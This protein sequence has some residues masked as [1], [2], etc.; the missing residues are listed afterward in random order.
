MHR[1][2]RGIH[3]TPCEG[4]NTSQQP[5]NQDPTLSHVRIS[6][7]ELKRQSSYAEYSFGSEQASCSHCLDESS[8]G[9][10]T[11]ST[12]RHADIC[13]ARF[14]TSHES[15]LS[16]RSAPSSTKIQLPSVPRPQEWKPLAFPIDESC[17]WA[18]RLNREEQRKTQTAK[19]DRL[20]R[21]GLSTPIFGHSR[22]MFG[23]RDT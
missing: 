5:V 22:S 11:P 13:K 7:I 14:E 15:T 4:L 3:G 18:D 1:V 23:I 10:I 16:L 6:T 2:T 19:S 12:S 9:W 17:A 8:S 20:R 21:L